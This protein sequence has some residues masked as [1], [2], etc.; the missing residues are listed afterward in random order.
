MGWEILIWLKSSEY[1]SSMPIHNHFSLLAGRVRLNLRLN[2]FSLSLSQTIHELAGLE[3]N[4]YP[5]SSQVVR[6]L[7]R[8]SPLVE[9]ECVG[10]W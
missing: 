8:G 3:N 4:K 5:Q 9:C 10:P 6:V 1:M 2:I 7:L